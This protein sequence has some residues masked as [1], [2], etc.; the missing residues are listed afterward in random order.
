MIN[1]ESGPG[2][3]LK[4]VPEPFRE[5]IGTGEEIEGGAN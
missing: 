4:K 5:T 2:D 1:Q 3:G